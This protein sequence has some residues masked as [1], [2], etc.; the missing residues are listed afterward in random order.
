MANDDDCFLLPFLFLHRYVSV[1]ENGD[2]GDAIRRCLDTPRGFR[3]VSDVP[4]K[5]ARAWEASSLGFLPGWMNFIRLVGLDDILISV[6]TRGLNV[7]M[8]SIPSDCG[9]TFD[10]FYNLKEM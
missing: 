7:R 3:F 8:V 4:V 5:S 2:A 1:D 10:N 9:T 6:A